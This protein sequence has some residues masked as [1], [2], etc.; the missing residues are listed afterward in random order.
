M[1]TGFLHKVLI[2]ESDDATTEK[3]S[4]LMESLELK[5][6]YSTSGPDAIEQIKNSK[7]S[8]SLIISAQTLDDEMNGTDFLSKTKELHPHA[9]RFLMTSS[10]DFKTIITAVNKGS[11]Q[12]CILKPW[13]SDMFIDAV[14]SGLARFDSYVEHQKLIKLAKNQNAKLYDLTSELMEATK[15]HDK[16]LKQLDAEIK[17]IEKIIKSISAPESD[18]PEDLIEQ[19]KAFVSS[20]SGIDTKKTQ[21]LFNLA[22]QSLYEQFNE[23]AQRNGFEMPDLE[24]DA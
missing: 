21:T 2:V 22:I 6:L 20:E 13:E 1:D 24:G 5:A 11:I 12:R 19:I 18:S 3:I 4:S 7:R 23:M 15:S 14:K 9:V 10:S 16:D 8:F 17:E